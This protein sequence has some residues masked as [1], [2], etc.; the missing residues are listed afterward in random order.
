MVILHNHSKAS[1][2]F[3]EDGVA[4]RQKCNISAEATKR[5]ARSSRQSRHGTLRPRELNLLEE[6]NTQAMD[7]NQA[8]IAV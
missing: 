1:C 2:E 8:V 5:L 6:V 7:R 4:R 3:C